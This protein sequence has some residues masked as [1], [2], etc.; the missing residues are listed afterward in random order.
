MDT[1]RTNPYIIDVLQLIEAAARRYPD[2][3][4]LAGHRA[5]LLAECGDN[6]GSLSACE[7]FLAKFGMD[8]HILELGLGLRRQLGK[9]DRCAVG[10]TSSVSLCMIVKNEERCLARC[11]ASVKPIVDEMIVVDTGSDDHTV[12]I[13]TLFGAAIHRFDW[14]GS[15]SDARNHALGKA[16]G[17]WILIMD[18]D[19]VIG[20]RDNV[21][22]RHCLASCE[23]NIA[24]QVLTRNYT[25]TMQIEGWEA[26]D[27]SCPEDEQGSGW[28]PSRK[29]RLFRNDARIRFQGAVHELVEPSLRENEITTIAAQFV[30]HHYGELEKKTDMEKKRRYYKLGR[31]KLQENP[32]DAAAVIELAIQAGELSLYDEALELWDYLLKINSSVHDVHFNRSHCLMSLKRYPEALLAA[33]RA[34]ELD[35]RHK[36]SLFNQATCEMYVGD[37]KL[38]LSIADALVRSHPGYFPAMALLIAARMALGIDN[39]VPELFEKLQSANIAVLDYL[40]EREKMLRHC[41]R[42]DLANNLSERLKRYV[43]ATQQHAPA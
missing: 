21:E 18:A 9:H 27:G 5:E 39:G 36:E 12:A 11:L 20:T 25:D 7:S 3:R 28:I 17:A 32:D 24:W 26:N 29:V 8:D 43:E 16:Q 14:N 22:I 10:S 38:A 6:T 2:S 41:K 1:A 4:N 42:S 19:E 13:A 34:A 35:P 31:Q 33:R 40:S 23:S 15:F 30:I 37:P